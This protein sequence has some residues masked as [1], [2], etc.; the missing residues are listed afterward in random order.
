MRF[1]L[2]ISVVVGGCAGSSSLVVRGP[3]PEDSP[4]RRV[5]FPPPPARVE[6][7][8]LRRRPECRYRDGYYTSEGGNWVWKP[9]LWVV[10]PDGC[11]Y[12]PPET[13]YESTSAGR[14]LVHRPGGFFEKEPPHRA[15]GD[16]PSCDGSAESLDG[17]A[18]SE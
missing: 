18:S 6:F 1:F 2:A 9:G 8:P 17:A 13:G 3:M 16:V 5:A 14:V 10:V 4:S 7:I 12:A 11:Y 15:C